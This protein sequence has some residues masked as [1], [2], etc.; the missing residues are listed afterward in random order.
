MSSF[1]DRSDQNP[2]AQEAETERQVE[3]PTGIID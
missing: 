1:P 3:A 2:M